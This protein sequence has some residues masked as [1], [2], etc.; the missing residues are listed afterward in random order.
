MITL[1]KVF[2]STYRDSVL[3]MR[4]ASQL[5]DR[6]GIMNAEIIMATPVNKKFLLTA[7]MKIDKMDEAGANDILV[8]V[9][10]DSD[11]AAREAVD[12]AERLLL[13]GIDET[14][15]PSSNSIG[16]ALVQ[17]PKANLALISVP[18]E[19]VRGVALNALKRG[20]NLFI[21]SDNVPLQEEKEIKLLAK[22]KELLVMGP[23]CG[24]SI[25]NG[26]ALGFANKVRR[27]SVGLVGASGT[28]LQEVTTLIHRYGLG[29]SNALGTGSNDISEAVGGVTMLK[30]IDMLEEDPLTKLIVIISKPPAPAVRE[31][32]LERLSNCAKPVVVNFLGYT[33]QN[34][35]N[36][37]HTVTLEDAAL[38][39]AE[40]S[41]LKNN[42]FQDFFHVDEEITSAAKEKQKLL[43]EGQRYVR[44]LYA[45]GT[46]ATEAGVIMREMTSYLYGNISLEG[47][48]TADPMKSKENTIIDLGMD[49]FTVG[50]PHPMI[51]STLRGERLVAEA[52][53]PE[54]AV[55]LMDFILGYGSNPDP[56]GSMAGYIKKAGAVANED[57][58]ELVLVASVC[59]TEDDPQGLNE[60]IGQLESLGV[61]VFPSNDKATKAAMIIA[62]R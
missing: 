46:L 43:F 36:I 25:I 33:S 15:V 37:Y 13:E 42:D 11:A 61:L 9:M 30:G 18:G 52:R 3:L 48:N 21:F 55:I 26:V 35:G 45:G 19:Y 17:I 51:D 23:D 62:S 2:H 40:L 31:R 27:G 44:G 7:G 54:V 53:D 24:T 57:G 58:R 32:V 14:S 5:R 38:K 16:G 60:Q 22:E 50:R 1:S 6:P 49:E 39:A 59:G 10:A 28:G 12:E 8:A 47:V 4:L 29:I 34:K 20:L 41:G 56:V